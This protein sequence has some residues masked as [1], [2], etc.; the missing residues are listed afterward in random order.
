MPKGVHVGFEVVGSLRTSLNGL[1]SSSALAHLPPPDSPPC[2]TALGWP[3]HPVSSLLLLLAR[4]MPAWFTFWR[5]SCP[6]RSSPTACGGTS[7]PTVCSDPLTHAHQNAS[8]WASSGASSCCDKDGSSR[9]QCPPPEC[10]RPQ[11]GGSQ[12]RGHGREAG[13][14]GESSASPGSPVGQRKP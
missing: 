10:P 3:R 9:G 4:G 12:R 8:A 2:E 1:C 14:A 5:Q 13:L 6:T 11:R 7:H